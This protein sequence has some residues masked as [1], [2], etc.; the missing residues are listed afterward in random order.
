MG[1]LCSSS[2]RQLRRLKKFREF[3]T[4]ENNI[5]KLL[6]MKFLK[7]KLKIKPSN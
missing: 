2:S 7:K 1:N 6:K 3:K 4:R 5:K